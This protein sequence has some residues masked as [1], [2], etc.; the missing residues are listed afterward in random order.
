GVARIQEYADHGDLRHNSNCFDTSADEIM[1]TPVILPPGRLKLATSPSLTGLLP[2]TNTIGIAVV[3]PLAASGETVLPVAVITATW[4]RTGS[5]AS[6]A[7][8][9]KRPSGKRS[10][11]AT[12]WLSTKPVKTGGREFRNEPVGHGVLLVVVPPASFS[13]GRGRSTAGPSHWRTRARFW[14]YAG[15]EPQKRSRRSRAPTPNWRLS[16]R[17]SLLSEPNPVLSAIC[18]SFNGVVCSKDRAS[19]HRSFWTAS[20]GVTPVAATNLR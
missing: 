8:L 15:P 3:A 20:A 17:R 5:D 10:A 7:R 2:A 6:A 13:C 14:D 16:E 19:S 9:S 1:L 11:I 12:V 18:A 4:R